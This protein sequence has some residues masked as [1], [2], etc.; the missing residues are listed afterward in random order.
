MR[1]K[2][3]YPERV[4]L[5]TARPQNLVVIENFDESVIIRAQRDN[6]SPREKACFIRY[7]AAEGYIPEIYQWF[8]DPDSECSLHATWIVN[9]GRVA[10]KRSS[11]KA[12]RQILRIIGCAGLVWLVLMIFA[13]LHAPR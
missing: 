8:A 12:L 9:E 7:L 13:F 4:K 3:A 5:S 2:V 6:F 11:N 10:V 1:A